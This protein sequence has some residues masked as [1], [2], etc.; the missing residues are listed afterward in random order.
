[1]NYNLDLSDQSIDAYITLFGM[2]DQNIAL[3]EEECNVHVVLQKNGLI[4]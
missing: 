2:N 4:L 1:M 3:I